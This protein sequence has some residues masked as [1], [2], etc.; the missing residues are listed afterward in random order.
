MAWHR[1]LVRTCF[2]ASTGLGLIAYGHGAN[3]QI[4]LDQYLPNPN[5]GYGADYM[6]RGSGY[7]GAANNVNQDA[8]APSITVTTRPHPEYDPV[9][10]RL[11]N[12]RFDAD[13]GENIGIDTNPLGL[14]HAKS[15]GFNNTQAEA[16]VD[17]TF[18]RGGVT[19]NI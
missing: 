19:G 6:R 11:G 8:L 3:A 2:L 5:A 10:V 17:G 12:W 13:A 9:G 4:L 16:N 14:S 1:P 15:S 7:G 18:D